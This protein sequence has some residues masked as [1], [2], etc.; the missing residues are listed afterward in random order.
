MR[1]DNVSVPYREAKD[2]SEVPPVEGQMLEGTENINCR[3]IVMAV[4]EL[5]SLTTNM[6][7]S[8]A[9]SWGNAR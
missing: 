3:C 7:T 2:S 6:H 5:P 1:A 9:L 8:H 4:F